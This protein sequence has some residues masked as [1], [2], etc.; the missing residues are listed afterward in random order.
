MTP[1]R[2]QSQRGWLL[3]A[4]IAVPVS[5]PGSTAMCTAQEGRAAAFD[6]VMA[7]PAIYWSTAFLLMSFAIGLAAMN[8]VRHLAASGK[9]DELTT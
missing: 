5:I 1:R 3:V 9:P 2:R 7:G 8:V 4:L 6:G